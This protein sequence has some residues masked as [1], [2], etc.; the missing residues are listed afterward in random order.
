MMKFDIKIE[1]KFTHNNVILIKCYNVDAFLRTKNVK[2][3]LNFDG[4]DDFSAIVD[5][6]HKS[7]LFFLS[8]FFFN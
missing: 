6:V 1:L 5:G 2:K 3:K 4:N 8:L 7:T